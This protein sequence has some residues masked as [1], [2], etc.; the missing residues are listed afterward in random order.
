GTAAAVFSGPPSE[1]SRF[2]EIK[3]PP[4]D[5][6]RRADDSCDPFRCQMAAS[7]C[8]NHLAR[9]GRLA[10]A[11]A[12]L[13]MHS[14]YLL[15]RSEIAISLRWFAELSSAGVPCRTNARARYRH[16]RDRFSRRA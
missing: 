1:V 4:S 6:P 8:G 2:F 14:H 12:L 7:P 5:W 9:E 11:S 15:R 3:D 13:L 10:R 16:N